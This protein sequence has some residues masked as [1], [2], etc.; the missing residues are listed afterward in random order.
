MVHP[1]VATGSMGAVLY[2]CDAP[3]NLDF[4]IDCMNYETGPNFRGLSMIPPG[5]H[6][7]YFS[8]GLGSRQG[9]FVFCEERDFIVRSWDTAN[10]EITPSNSL[11]EASMA[12][13]TQSLERGEL[14][15][16]LGPYP[17]P[18]HRAWLSLSSHISATV[19]E[20][21]DCSSGSNIIP[22]AAE[23]MEALQPASSSSRGG[24]PH[25]LPPTS[26][27]VKLY[28]PGLARV[29]RFADMAAAEAHLRE[30]THKSPDRARLLTSLYRDKSHLSRHVVRTCFGDSLAEL[31]GETQLAFVLFLLVFSHPAL[32]YWKAAVHLVCSSESLLKQQ[33]T[34]SAAF[35]KSLHAQL[36]FSPEDF[37]EIELSRENFLRPS[38][39]ALFAALSGADVPDPLP[40]CSRRLLKFV[41][42]KFDL[43]D[44]QAPAA[45]ADHADEAFNL[46]DEDMPVVVD[47]RDASVGAVGG[48]ADVTDGTMDTDGGMLVRRGNVYEEER[49]QLA[50]NIQQR[51]SVFDA[52]VTTPLQGQQQG[53]QQ[54]QAR[55]GGVEAEAAVCLGPPK[56]R[57]DTATGVVVMADASAPS[58][59][60]AELELA[61]FC[62]RYPLLHEANQAAGGREDLIMT[63][64]RLL[65]EQDAAGDGGAEGGKER[66]HLWREAALFIENEH[67]IGQK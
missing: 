14:N 33:P 57:P 60:R 8:T 25:Q 31:L 1:K 63:A 50:E 3:P 54:G 46:V 44:G 45:W 13:L 17:F 55:A 42:K 15:H 10:E 28:F 32:V 21:A 23:D 61:L 26:S 24:A 16:Q 37:F 62:W 49:A 11:S 22:G 35:V 39:S 51:W 4:G 48:D 65:G 9:F 29:A 5:L 18:Q 7:V 58:M 59:S 41:K 19:L 40:E 2:I 43:Y 47:E 56:R 27:A 34:F 64:V 30:E 52:M 6:F 20:R 36:N 12:S 67:T 53:Q 38:L 66:S